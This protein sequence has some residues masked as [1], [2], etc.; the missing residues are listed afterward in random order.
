VPGAVAYWTRQQAVAAA[1]VGTVE[2]LPDPTMA[3]ATPSL[4]GP[5]LDGPSLDGPSLDGPSLDGPS[6]DGPS[7]VAVLRVPVMRDAA[8]T[9]LLFAA[10]DSR[11]PFPPGILDTAAVFPAS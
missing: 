3:P 2:L 7:L 6:L 10:R 1:G 8:P 4:D 11:R 9:A 5:S